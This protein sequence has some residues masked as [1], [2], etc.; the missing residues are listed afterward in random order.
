[1]KIVG[2]LVRF[3]FFVLV[4]TLIFNFVEIGFGIYIMIYPLFIFLLPQDTNIYIVLLL[5]FVMGGVI[6]IISD[7]FGLH[8][9]SLVMFAFLRSL[10]LSFFAPRDGYE[11]GKEMNLFQMGITWFVRVFGLLLLLFN[12][13]FFL[14]EQFKLNNILHVLQKT[15][16]STVL[17]LVICIFFQYLFINRSKRA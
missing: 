9:S 6:D 13:Y 17:C 16:L 2:L 1:M 11:S 3:L 12:F 5:S 10:F 15:I 4:Q 8:A 7:T 14:L